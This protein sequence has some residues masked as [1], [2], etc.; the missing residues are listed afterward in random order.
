VLAHGH[1]RSNAGLDDFAPLGHW[2]DL[3]PS[4]ARFWFS[5]RDF[6]QAKTNP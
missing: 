1:H 3:L 4:A 5:C 2:D 6:A